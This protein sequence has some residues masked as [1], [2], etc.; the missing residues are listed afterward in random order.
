MRQI[1]VVSRQ[2]CA[3]VQ[4]TSRSAAEAA[5]EKS[6]NKLIINGRRL[7]IKWG[8]SQAQQAARKEEEDMHHMEPVPGLPGGKESC[9]SYL[10]YT[11]AI[12]FY[13]H[14]NNIESGLGVIYFVFGYQRIHLYDIVI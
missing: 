11:H 5:S 1:T 13:C 12:V 4:F 9:M 6:F 7:N 10:L 2:Q 3:F 8:R 14:L